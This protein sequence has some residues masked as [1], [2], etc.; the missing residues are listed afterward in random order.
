MAG[1]K[2]QLENME[3]IL[4]TGGTGFIGSHLLETLNTKKKYKIF[5][6]YLSIDKKSY[7]KTTQMDKKVN[8]I[9]IDLSQTLKTNR[10]LSKIKPDIIIHLAAEAIVEECLKNPHQAF[11][12]NILGTVNILEYARVDKKIKGVIIA[13]SDKAYGKHG[14]KKYIETDSLHGDHPYEVSKS[15]ADL[16]TSS[17]YKTYGVPTVITRFGNAYGEGDLHFSRLIPGLIKSSLENK[18]FKI[19]SDGKFV[20]DYIYV[21]DVAQAYLKIAEN[22]ERLKGEAFNFGSEDTLSVLDVIDI[23]NNGTHKKIKYQILNNQ[24]NE[25]PYQSLDYS[26]IKRRIG[27]KPK[28]KMKEVIGKIYSWYESVL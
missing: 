14:K 3:K 18:T 26:K 19:R 21:K 9:K 15:S 20:R 16:I 10:V 7:F 22:I 4:V 1:R 13:S 23:F 6:T 5:T 11:M 27:W 24:K 2:S 17:Y 8:A 12:S 25:I 28:N